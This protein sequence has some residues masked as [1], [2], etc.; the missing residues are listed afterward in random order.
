MKKAIL[1]I[2][3]LLAMQI[4]SASSLVV[5]ALD[6]TTQVY[7]M[8]A[9]SK[10]DFTTSGSLKVVKT[11]KSED[12]KSISATRKVVFS[13]EDA[14]ATAIAENS[15]ASVLKVYPNPAKNEITVEGA[16]DDI[17][18]F[19]ANGGLVSSTKAADKAVVN[20]SSL[21]DGVYILRSGKSAA[22]IIKTK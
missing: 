10:L 2:S 13:A 14:P 5:E 1:I 6:G 17:L 22:R 9:V 18:I 4:A 15:S 12:V 19:S 21:A 20:V 3:S 7:D 11:D 16:S 8:A